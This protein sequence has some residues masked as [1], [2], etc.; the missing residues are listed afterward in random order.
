[1]EKVI[2]QVKMLG[3]RLAWI[4]SKLLAIK[5]HIYSIQYSDSRGFVAVAL[6]GL[7]AYD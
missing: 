7:V 6:L 3:F 4:P 5:T 1:M 2:Y